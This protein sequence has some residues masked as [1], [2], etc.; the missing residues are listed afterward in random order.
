[1]VANP[2]KVLNDQ[3]LYLT[4]LSGEILSFRKIKNAGHPVKE[5]ESLAIQTTL[6]LFKDCMGHIQLLTGEKV[7]QIFVYKNSPY[8]IYPSKFED[9][10]SLL[11]PVKAALND[12]L[13]IQK[14]TQAKNETFII[15][16]GLGEY[17][18]INTVTDPNGPYRY[19]RPIDFLEGR[20]W[21]VTPAS[22]YIIK[23]SY[24]RFVTAPIIQR[25]TDIAIFDFFGNTINFFDA[26]GKALRSV[27]ISFHLKEYYELLIVKRH[28]IDLDNFTQQI[29]YDEK[30]NR[31]WSVW[32]R[33]KDGRYSLKEINPDTGEVVRVVDIPDFPFIDKIRIHDNIIYFLYLE[34]KYPYYRS[35]YRMGI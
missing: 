31:I 14:S 26:D 2:F 34:K 11:Y 33:K 20:P 12:R 22:E 27:P 29:L 18:L 17:K 30:A 35:L 24:K 15:S 9:F 23:G 16:K 10:M 1:M 28:D 6:Y 7:W 21:P 4:T 8:L 19:A 5:T 13:F 32:H 3:R 25:S